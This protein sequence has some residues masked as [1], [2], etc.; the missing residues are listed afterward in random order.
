M[1]IKLT[2][3]YIDNSPVAEQNY[4]IWDTLIP[5][6]FVMVYTNG[7]KSFYCQFRLKNKKQKKAKIGDFPA[8]LLEDARET[9]KKWLAI[10]ADGRDPIEEIKKR[11][12]QLIYLPEKDGTVAELYEKFLTDYADIEMKEGS[13]RNVYSYWKNHIKP[14]LQDKKVR[15]V[16]SGDI[17]TLKITVANK[18]NRKGEPMIV[19]ANRVMEVVSSMFNRAEIWGWRDRHTNPVEDITHFKE[20]KRKR[21]PTPEEAQRLGN[22]LDEYIRRG[23]KGNNYSRKCARLFLLLLYTGARRSEMR[24]AKWKWL[25]WNKAKIFLPD[26]KSNEP[27]EIEIPSPAME[28]LS[29]MYQ[30]RTDPTHPYIFEGKKYHQHLA[31][32]KRIWQRIKKKAKLEDFRVHDLRHAFASFAVIETK[33]LPMVGGLLHHKDGNTTNRY[34]HLMDDPLRAAVENTAFRIGSAL[35]GDRIVLFDGKAVNPRPAT[36]MQ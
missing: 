14:L 13:R 6:L 32:E 9:A 31:D 35:W 18:K 5:G 23:D 15:A 27:I 10:A 4:N 34:A 30:E 28:I 3:S 33:S 1:K 25:D 36:L 29:E 22:V 11:A 17:S 7:R 8:V 21:Y 19:T 20:K 2:K 16:S 12:A 26:S 24:N